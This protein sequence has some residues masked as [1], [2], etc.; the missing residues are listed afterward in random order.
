MGPHFQVFGE[1]RF[2][3][4]SGSG[5]PASS[6]LPSCPEDAPRKWRRALLISHAPSRRDTLPFI[7]AVHIP[8]LLP[9]V[10]IDLSFSVRSSLL[11][12]APLAPLPFLLSSSP[13]FCPPP[14]SRRDGGG[15]AGDGAPGA[16]ARE[17]PEDSGGG[18]GGNGGVGS[19]GG[20]GGWGSSFRVS[21]LSSSR[22]LPRCCS[23]PPFPSPMIVSNSPSPSRP[24]H[25]SSFSPFFLPLSSPPAPGLVAAVGR[26]GAAAQAHGESRVREE[27]EHRDLHRDALASSRGHEGVPTEA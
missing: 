11:L 12:L 13:C 14:G 19:G 1:S 3:F 20:G 16:P 4:S 26:R 10:L 2:L 6:A 21:C 25:A 17:I 27:R 24:S 5:S 9:T 8:A 7:C 15:P 18:L 22:P 23:G